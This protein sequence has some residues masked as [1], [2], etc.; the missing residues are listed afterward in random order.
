MKTD[1]RLITEIYCNNVLTQNQLNENIFTDAK[2]KLGGMWRNPFRKETEAKDPSREEEINSILNDAAEKLKNLNVDPDKLINF[3][4]VKTID[5]PPNWSSPSV[6]NNDTTFNTKT[7]TEDDLRFAPKTEPA[8]ATAQKP[9]MVSRKPTYTPPPKLDLDAY[10]QEKETYGARILR[11][12]KANMEAKNKGEPIP[13]PELL[14][15]PTTPPEPMPEP[16]PANVGGGN[17]KVKSKKA[18]V[19][20][21]VGAI[22]KSSTT[23]SK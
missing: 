15:K 22:K 1:D 23:K 9:S 12:A 21:K 19:K 3:E 10:A 4:A 6:A 11:K 20:K 2:E 13:Y 16:S 17:S 5:V 14:K 18:P 7:E 8:P